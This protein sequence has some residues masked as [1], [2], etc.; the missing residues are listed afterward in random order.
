VVFVD[1]REGVFK[2]MM[3]VMSTQFYPYKWSNLLTLARVLGDKQILEG[4]QERTLKLEALTGYDLTSLET[5]MYNSDA[6]DNFIKTP[7]G[8][9][10][11]LDIMNS[12]SPTMEWLADELSRVKRGIRFRSE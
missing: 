5:L 4:L 11:E 3:Q 1:P 7:T 6:L 2:T 10:T 9:V 12:M 8:R